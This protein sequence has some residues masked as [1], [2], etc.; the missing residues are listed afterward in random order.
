MEESFVTRRKDKRGIL[1]PPEEEKDTNSEVSIHSEDESI[2][3]PSWEEELNK[4][5]GEWCPIYKKVTTS[6]KL[7]ISSNPK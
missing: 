2:Q 7:K 1:E 3:T 6:L 4:E 5:F